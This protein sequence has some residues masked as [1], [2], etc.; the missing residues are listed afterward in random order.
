MLMPEIVS[1]QQDDQTIVL[2]LFIAENVA[3]FEGHF[4]ETPILAGVV[5]LDWAVEL[6]AEAFDLSSKLVK[7]VQVLKFQNVIRPNSTVT[8]EL[9]LSQTNK[10]SFKYVSE[11]GVHASGRV[12]LEE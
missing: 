8:L 1:K 11:H 10:F 7:E 9:T 3:Y 2:K 5:Q 4:P 12:L 6:A